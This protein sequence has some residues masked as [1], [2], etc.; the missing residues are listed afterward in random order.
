VRRLVLSLAALLC[1][2]LTVVACGSA[3]NDY[4]GKVAEVQSKY[5]TQMTDL[6]TKLTAEIS[7]DPAAASASLSQLAT[8]VGQFA[9]DV[10][11]VKPPAG[12]E[13]LADQL[14]GAYRTLAQASL[15]LK[16]ALDAKDTTALDKALEEFNKATAD[17]S[18]AVDAFNAA[19]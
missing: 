1:L 11:D 12:K 3:T 16:K 14:V 15:D 4:R 6:T 2:A 7:T 5:S 17:E 13:P 19:E 18:A 8:V 9:E 10:A